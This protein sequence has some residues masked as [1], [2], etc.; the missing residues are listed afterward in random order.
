[1]LGGR[2]AA[3]SKE[4]SRADARRKTIAVETL[5]A[6]AKGMR[7][8][9]SLYAQL[10]STV[11]LVRLDNRQRSRRQRSFSHPTIRASTLAWNCSSMAAQFRS[12]VHYTGKEK[13]GRED[14]S[15]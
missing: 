5:G 11:P 4:R 14:D 7:A 10:A 6:Q 8:D 1:M 15:C 13:Q 2:M 12:D 9:A 3:N